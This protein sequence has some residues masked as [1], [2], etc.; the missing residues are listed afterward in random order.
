MRRCESASGTVRRI[1]QTKFELI[2]SRFSC[3]LDKKKAEAETAELR[4]KLARAE[5]EGRAAKDDRDRLADSLQLANQNLNASEAK[6]IKAENE[7]DELRNEV[8]IF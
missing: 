5:N 8:C 4:K 3:E 2:V 7:N 6:R 1:L